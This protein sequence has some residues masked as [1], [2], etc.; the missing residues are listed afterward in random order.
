M[1]PGSGIPGSEWLAYAGKTPKG[2]GTAGKEV[3][4]RPLAEERR[5]QSWTLERSERPSEDSS[6]KQ[7]FLNG[8]SGEHLKDQRDCQGRRG[9][10]EA[11]TIASPIDDNTRK[12]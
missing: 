1:T 4:Q 8:R 9:S 5:H 3:A 6:G 12:A 7:T 11:N 2:R 10:E